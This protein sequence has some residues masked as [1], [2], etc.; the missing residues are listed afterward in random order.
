MHI[1]IYIYTYRYIWGPDSR[2]QGSK[3]GISRRASGA[4]N[5]FWRV[6]VSDASSY[7]HQD[8]SVDVQ[9]QFWLDL[10]PLKGALGPSKTSWIPYSTSI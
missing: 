9:E 8:S 6:P 1:Y 3:P 7:R 5:D 10:G 2:A 4:Q